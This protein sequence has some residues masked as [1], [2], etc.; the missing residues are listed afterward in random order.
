MKSAPLSASSSKRSIM[1][2]LCGKASCED[3]CVDHFAATGSTSVE[4]H[5]L[6]PIA[7]I[8][9]YSRGCRRTKD[10]TFLLAELFREDGRIDLGSGRD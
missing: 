4:T 3:T 6:L 7:V 5:I 1:K 10:L 2:G 8:L 9:R